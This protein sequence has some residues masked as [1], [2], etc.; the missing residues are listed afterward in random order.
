M[1]LLLSTTG[2]LLSFVTVFF[3][4]M[5]LWMSPNRAPLS[6]CAFLFSL[7]FSVLA[8]EMAGGGGGPGGGGGGGGGMAG[9]TSSTRHNLENKTFS[10]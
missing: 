4:F 7:G 10:T 9:C 5:P 3:N 8:W 6:F 2:A 1:L